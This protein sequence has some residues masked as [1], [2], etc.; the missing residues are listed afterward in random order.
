[1]LPSSNT[2]RTYSLLLLL[3]VAAGLTVSLPG[4]ILEFVFLRVAV[5]LRASAAGVATLA[6]CCALGI[7]F[8]PR[9][10]Y[11]S[12]GVIERLVLA[13][14]SG[15]G[16]LSV[17]TLGLG[18]VGLT[19]PAMAWSLA[20]A[21]WLAG[22]ARLAFL[23]QR[24]DADAST[25]Q[26]SL[27]QQ[28]ATP[29]SVSEQDAT[30]PICWTHRGAFVLSCVGFIL[31]AV[32][33]FAPP[34]LFD[35][36]EY[37]LGA[38]TDYAAHHPPRFTANGHNFYARFP[39]CLESIYYFGLMLDPAMDFAP[40][41]INAAFIAAA[42]VLIFSILRFW[43]AGISW[44]WLGVSLWLA[45]PVLREVSIDA[46]I[47]A[48]V[49]FF[50]AGAAFFALRAQGDERAPGSWLM[51]SALWLGTA[52]SAKYT[53]A[54]TFLFP[55]LLVLGLPAVRSAWGSRSGRVAVAMAALLMAIPSAAWLGKNVLFYGNPLEPFFCSLFRPGDAAAKA[56]EQFYIAGHYPQSPLT[57]GYWLTLVPRLREFGWV[58]LAPAVVAP[59]IF[60]GPLR[61][62]AMRLLGFV[63]L[64][65][66]LWNLVRESQNRFLLPAILL[67][68]CLGIKALST[69]SPGLVRNVTVAL[70]FCWASLHLLHQGLKLAASGEFKYFADFVLEEPFRA[71]RK[72]G[73]PLSPREEFYGTNLGA[74]GELLPKI[75]E[76]PSDA[77]ILL[78]YEARPYLISRQTVYNTV[79]D[80]SDLVR[81]AANAATAGD[82][83]RELRA[84]GITH[85]LVNREELR[86][87][88]QQYARPEQLK[89]LGIDLREDFAR[90]FYA[91]PTPE[92]QFPPFY[93]DAL[94]AARRAAIL[95]FLTLSRSKAV[96]V[97]GKAPLEIWLA[98]VM[99]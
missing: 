48:P 93:R 40:K 99:D 12:A 6:T 1:M 86:R 27:T 26:Q 44:R 10:I 51:L 47:D 33:A 75:K 76:L 87:Y 82:V 5:M 90:A 17:I 81:F 37:H 39:F 36:T 64:S 8:L 84:A 57:A 54:Q 74:L 69:L 19:S 50:V 53:V 63:F 92:D 95:E 80:D 16:F 60:S 43:N 29:Q 22:I 85:V 96:A 42:S 9:T 98:P 35:V 83:S 91:T 3:L 73:E 31:L 52:L 88:I 7:V 23:H 70:L 14:G 65:Y 71:A 45:H 25:T 38:W 97:V 49:A 89:K 79:W 67:L 4:G 21:C 41:L 77:K 61:R 18:L 56:R 15:V 72:A 59:W 55:F 94:W 30:P 68:V 46:F 66:L 2:A 78:V 28:S 58:V 13:F 24:A 34:L 11:M 62:E 32:T 20:V